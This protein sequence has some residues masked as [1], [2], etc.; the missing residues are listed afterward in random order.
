LIDRALDGTNEITLHDYTAVESPMLMITKIR[1]CF[2]SIISR[3]SFSLENKEFSTDPYI[4]RL[5]GDQ[6]LIGYQSF[7]GCK[8]IVERC[9]IRI[10]KILRNAKSISGFYFDRISALILGRSFSFF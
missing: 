9:N 6:S 7:L 4:S 3:E 8:V 5:I 2:F 10:L 1:A